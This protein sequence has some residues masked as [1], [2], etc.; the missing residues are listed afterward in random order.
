MAKSYYQVENEMP[1][2][3]KQLLVR[4]HW[5]VPEEE[6]FM[7]NH[8]YLFLHHYEETWKEQL[9]LPFV[10]LAYDE[11]T[12][13]YTILPEF[14]AQADPAEWKAY[15]D[16]MV[17]RFDFAIGQDLNSTNREDEEELSKRAIKQYDENDRLIFPKAVIP[18][19]PYRVGNED[20][21]DNYLEDIL[22]MPVKECPHTDDHGMIENRRELFLTHFAAICMKYA[23][24]KLK[25]LF[26]A[27][28]NPSFIATNEQFSFFKQLLKERQTLANDEEQAIRSDFQEDIEAE[29]A[30]VRECSS[31]DDEDEEGDDLGENPEEVEARRNRL[32]EMEGLVETMMEMYQ[33]DW[34]EENEQHDFPS[35]TSARSRQVLKSFHESLLLTS[36]VVDTYGNL[37]LEQGPDE[38]G[39]KM[40]LSLDCVE[41]DEETLKKEGG[42]MTNADGKK[43]RIVLAASESPIPKIMFN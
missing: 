15:K 20:Y 16:L 6:F 4:G 22:E 21:V 13:T 24:P 17:E 36:P 23:L 43:V 30:Y 31:Y 9:Q 7:E 40:T 39:N 14:L 26:D 12:R 38:F 25:V 8:N 11:E 32:D 42:H 37:D 29:T 19:L 1:L 33:K 5:T 2:R 10:P 27:E 3:A 34:E 18:K 28:N 35:D 41:I